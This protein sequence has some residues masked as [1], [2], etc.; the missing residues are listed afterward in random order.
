[1]KG[2]FKWQKTYFQKKQDKTII[3]TAV[4]KGERDRVGKQDLWM[5]LT[6]QFVLKTIFEFLNLLLF[7]LFTE[8]ISESP[9]VVR[10]NTEL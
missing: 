9:A 7:K 6:I 3:N 8:M 2:R 4:Q 5:Y 1:M 10:D